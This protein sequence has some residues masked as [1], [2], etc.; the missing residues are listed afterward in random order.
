MGNINITIVDVNN[1]LKSFHN[2]NK[3]YLELG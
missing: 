1:Y 3:R 2:N